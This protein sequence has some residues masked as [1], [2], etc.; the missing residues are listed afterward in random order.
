MTK[1]R[2]AVVGGGPSREHEISLRSSHAVAQALDTSKYA[3][4]MVFIT[5]TGEWVF[6]GEPQEMQLGAA[7]QR[8]KNECDVVFIAL[9]GMFGE[10]GTLQALLEQHGIPYTGS[11]PEASLLAMNKVVAGDL[12]VSAGL[13]V[14]KSF[15]FEI[16]HMVEAER[17]VRRDFK[18]PLIVKPVRQGSS[19]GV[20]LVREPDNLRA[21]M[22]DALLYDLQAMAQDYVAGRELSCGVLVNPRNQR[23]DALPPTE[24]IPK[25]DFFD[26]EGKYTPGATKE[27]TPPHLDA[28]TIGRIQSLAKTAHE[29]LGC[30]GYSRTDMIMDDQGDLY[31]LETNT[32]P[33]LTQTSILPQQAAVAHMSISEMLD[34]IIENALIKRS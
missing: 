6:G 1:I 3:V 4:E 27:I 30:Q 31:I 22:K 5:K 8:L 16:E 11:P 10:D 13:H 23:L 9:H 14:P 18:F 33:G 26:F 19:V 15:V 29:V 28:R 20:H 32:L 2:I 24:L 21:A 17:E 34:L 7:M 12:F 25:N